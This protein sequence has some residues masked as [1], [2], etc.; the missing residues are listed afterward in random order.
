MLGCRRPTPERAEGVGPW[1]D[2]LAF[3]TWLA[4]IVNALFIY[5]FNDRTVLS[6]LLEGDTLRVFIVLMIVWVAERAHGILYRVVRSLVKRMPSHIDAIVRAEEY[7]L[8]RHWLTR[9]DH[10][11]SPTTDDN[12]ATTSN[13][14]GHR[15]NKPVVVHPGLRKRTAMSGSEEEEDAVHDGTK[16]PMAYGLQEISNY[17]SHP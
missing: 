16:D 4:S 6:W 12:K 13:L 8:R 15:D 17:Y 1:L 2:I 14:Q 9:L 10:P 3:L 11:P 7:Q 5:Q